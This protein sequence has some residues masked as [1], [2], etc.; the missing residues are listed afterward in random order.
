[1]CVGPEEKPVEAVLMPGSGS[2]TVGPKFEFDVPEEAEV[3]GAEAYNDCECEDVLCEPSGIDL[4]VRRRS[5]SKVRNQ[6]PWRLSR[7]CRRRIDIEESSLERRLLSSIH[8]GTAQGFA[9]EGARFV[10]ALGFDG[11]AKRIPPGL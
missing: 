11:L 2:D 10:L 7:T 6:R 8:T 3:I 1:M 4:C 9:L 5:D